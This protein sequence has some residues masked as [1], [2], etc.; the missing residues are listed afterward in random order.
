MNLI[1]FLIGILFEF[2]AIAAVSIYE[3]Y[4]I[5]LPIIL[6]IHILAAYF[7]TKGIEKHLDQARL[8]RELCLFLCFFLPVLGNLCVIFYIYVFKRLGFKLKPVIEVNNDSVLY[9]WEN[10]LFKHNNIIHMEAIDSIL[11]DYSVINLCKYGLA[12]N[13]YSCKS[14]FTLK[15]IDKNKANY[16]EKIADLKERLKI[17]P[18]SNKTVRELADLYYDF[19]LLDITESKTKKLLCQKARKLYKIFLKQNHEDI[20]ILLKLIDINYMLKDYIACS[21]L[22][23]KALIIDQSNSYIYLRLAQ[24]YYYSGEF[25]KLYYLAKDIITKPYLSD[26]V[27]QIVVMWKN[28]V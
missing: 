1:M 21:L 5:Y 2:L 26:E 10:G 22:C 3:I 15:D 8:W 18:T 13:V 12:D 7:F 28:Y 11:K 4:P 24:C 20:K 9:D 25:L 6:V 27:K 19:V 14:Y 16:W 17:K 23:E